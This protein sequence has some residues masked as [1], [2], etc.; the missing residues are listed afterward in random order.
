[1]QEALVASSERNTIEL[2][3]KIAENREIQNKLDAEL[4]C[5]RRESDLLRRQLVVACGSKGHT[6]VTERESGVYGE[7]YIYCSECGVDWH[8]SGVFHNV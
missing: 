7:K 3:R 5:A 1:M 8:R 6:F 2:K 4:K